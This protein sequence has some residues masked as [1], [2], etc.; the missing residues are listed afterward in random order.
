MIRARFETE[1]KACE[2]PIEEGALI[3]QVDGLWCCEACVREH[4]EDE[5]E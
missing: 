5:D 4:G 3:G 1:C 2:Q